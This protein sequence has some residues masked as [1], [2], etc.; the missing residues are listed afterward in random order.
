MKE[1]T[2]IFKAV[3]N[4]F[5][6]KKGIVKEHYADSFQ[7]LYRLVQTSGCKFLDLSQELRVNISSQ[8]VSSLSKTCG[9]RIRK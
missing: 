4:K 7:Y 2:I 8:N 6:N 5:M 3:K 1:T 9:D